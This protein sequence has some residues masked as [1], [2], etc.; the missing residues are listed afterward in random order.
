[1]PLAD[2]TIYK[3]LKEYIFAVSV[4]AVRQEA[5]HVANDSDGVALPLVIR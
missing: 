5:V 2:V 4:L 3:R 1:M